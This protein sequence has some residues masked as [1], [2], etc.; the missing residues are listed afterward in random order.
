L[1]KTTPTL[2]VGSQ[3]DA[4]WWRA[5]A[6]LHSAMMSLARLLA[7][8]TVVVRGV[9]GVWAPATAASG[10]TW[11]YLRAKRARRND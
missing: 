4:S 10:S 2:H 5:S 11:S 3:K 9:A 6:G 8:P 7:Q 1:D